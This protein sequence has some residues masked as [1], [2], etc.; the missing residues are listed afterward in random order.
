MFYDGVFSSLTPQ[1]PLVL[2]VGYG[3]DDQ[4]LMLKAARKIVPPVQ[5]ISAQNGEDA[6]DYVAGKGHFSRRESYPIPSLIIFDLKTPH[7]S[8]LDTLRKLSEAKP[9]KLPLC[10]LSSFNSKTELN[11]VPPLGADDYQVKPTS[12]NDLSR[13]L[14]Q[15][16]KKFC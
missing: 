8:S 7:V 15:L 3:S 10:V 6:A 5:I 13:L 12:F 14:A 9:Q 11:E 16:T 1:I 2:I 4:L